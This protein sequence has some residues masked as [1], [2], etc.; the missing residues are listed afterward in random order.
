MIST[1]EQNVRGNEK[2][3]YPTSRE[4]NGADALADEAMSE[5]EQSWKKVSRCDCFEY[6]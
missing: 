5:S 2:I 6:S 4:S 1:Y 3:R